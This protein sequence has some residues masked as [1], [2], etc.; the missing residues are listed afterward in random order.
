MRIALLID[1]NGAGFAG[2]QTQP[3]ARGVQD[4][5]ELALTAIAGHRVSTICAGRTDAGVH[6]T[7]QVVHFDT[8][9]QRPLQAWVRG[10]NAHLPSA[11]AVQWAYQVPDA[12]D[13]RFS[14][15]SRR[16]EYW[17]YAAPTRSA[18][19]NE[20]VGW[21][22][23]ALDA[24]AMLLGARALLG[25]HDFSAF[26]SAECQAKSPIRTVHQIDVERS[27]RFVRV[28]VE[29]NA[30]LHHMVRNIVGALLDIGRGRQP[31]TWARE[32]LDGRDRR[33]ASPTASASGLYLTGV[34]YDDHFGLPATAREPWP[35]IG[36]LCDV[37]ASNSV[38]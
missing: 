6:A 3:G 26:R 10:V 12:F 19:L 30:F 15:R 23:Q 34:R 1:Y 24:H 20:R 32:L 21:V 29:A 14:A 22:F 17:V 33:R 11:V 35:S 13:A 18:L 38:D 31:V 27:G 37:P 9:A 2:W 5:V 28:R 16:Y 36:A 7:A 25:T 8:V 4:A